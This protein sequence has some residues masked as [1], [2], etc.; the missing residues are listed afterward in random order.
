MLGRRTFL[1]LTG[2]GIA[3]GS[4]ASCGGDSGDD[5]KKVEVFTWWAQGSEKADDVRLGGLL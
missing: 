1:A 4:L 5:S 3:A 2:A